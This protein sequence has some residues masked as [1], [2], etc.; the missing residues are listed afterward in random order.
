MHK[1]VETTIDLRF[2]KL[3]PNNQ[4]LSIE[5]ELRKVVFQSQIHCELL[6]PIFC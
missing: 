1:D 3:E 6:L 4:I 2:P 5:V